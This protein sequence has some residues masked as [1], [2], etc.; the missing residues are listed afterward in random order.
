MP[1]LRQIDRL[2]ILRWPNLT[3]EV[4]GGLREELQQIRNFIQY[5]NIGKDELKLLIEKLMCIKTKLT[6]KC[7]LRK[8]ITTTVKDIRN[9]LRNQH[10]KVRHK[11]IRRR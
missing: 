7:P 11:Y 3:P 10:T 6:P 1:T 2:Y 8:D 9:I 5:L 4:L